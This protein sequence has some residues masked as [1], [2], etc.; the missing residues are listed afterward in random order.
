MLKAA[1]EKGMAVAQDGVYGACQGPRL[2]TA[3]EIDRM[4][5]D[6]CDSVGMTGMPEAVL[7]RELGLSYACCAV[8]ANW[9]AGRVPK[10]GSIHA[11]IRENLEKGVSQ[12]C[13]LL[14]ALLPLLPES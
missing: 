6:G 10:G 2:E 4:E 5:R 12:A 9:A 13:A 1:G 3:A 8:V 11:E 7:A 14:E